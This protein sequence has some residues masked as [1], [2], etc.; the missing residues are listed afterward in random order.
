MLQKPHVAVGAER[1]SR[2]AQFY[3]QAG[4]VREARDALRAAATHASCFSF[5][6]QKREKQNLRHVE[7]P[8]CRQGVR[9]I[10]GT[11]ADAAAIFEYSSTYCNTQVRT[12]VPYCGEGVF[13]WSI[14]GFC[15]TQ[16]YAYRKCPI[17]IILARVTRCFLFYFGAIVFYFA[18]AGGSYAHLSSHCNYQKH[19]IHCVA[20]ERIIQRAISYG[21][22]PGCYGIH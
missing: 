7:R 21:R 1:T 14:T 13:T 19:K 5:T 9:L 2:T 16:L 17:C 22:T 20:R 4:W 15:G 6:R 10:L 12:R 3:S 18:G 11:A 8:A